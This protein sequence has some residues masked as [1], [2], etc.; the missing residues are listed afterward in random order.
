M[1]MLLS[2]LIVLQPHGDNRRLTL[3]GHEELANQKGR[4]PSL[5]V[6]TPEVPAGSGLGR[7]P[8][9]QTDGSQGE[10]RI[11][12]EGCGRSFNPKA[13]ATHARICAKVGQPGCQLL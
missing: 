7:L 4:I 9:L 3:A 6:P 11:K 10:E 13:Y 5:E 2:E 8:G 1:Q 12:C